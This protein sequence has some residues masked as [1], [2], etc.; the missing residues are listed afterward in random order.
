MLNTNIARAGGS[1]GDEAGGATRPGVLGW[2][3]GRHV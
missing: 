3:L 1:T 2:R